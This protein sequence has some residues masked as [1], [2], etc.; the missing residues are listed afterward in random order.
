MINMKANSCDGIYC[1][2]LDVRFTKACDNKCAFCI[3][4]NGLR[5][6]E[7]NVEKMIESTLKSKKQDILILGGEPLLEIKKVLFY[8]R[9][10]RKHVKRIYLTTSLPY[11]II[12]YWST[13]LQIMNLIDGLNVSLQH[14]DYEENNKVLNASHP[15]DRIKLLKKICEDER[16]AN[17]VRVSINLVKGKID[18]KIEIDKFLCVMKK[19]NVKHVKI[20]ELQHSEEWYVSFCDAYEMKMKSPFAH[21]CQTDIELSEF[22]TIRITLK[23][24][25][26]CVNKHN[27]ASIADFFKA[28]VNAVNPSVKTNH[29]LVLC[30]NGWLADGWVN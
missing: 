24:S 26:F 5:A 10:I 25:C 20:N 14:Y 6:Q 11:K 29:L 18:S 2:S 12:E 23:R 15:F 19:M 1:N 22:K 28:V 13:F 30:E 8:V 7:I 16:C 27:V 4:K 9:N 21:G 17:K 3:E